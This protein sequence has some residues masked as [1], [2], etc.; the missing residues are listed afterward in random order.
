[1]FRQLRALVMK[2]LHP[3]N[4]P[5]GM[6]RVVRQEVFKAIWPKIEAMTQP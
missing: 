4:A 6:D 2:E 3:D 5:A 1:M